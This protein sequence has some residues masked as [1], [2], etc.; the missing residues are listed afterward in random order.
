MAALTVSEY[1]RLQD[2][3][4]FPMQV[5]NEPAVVEQTPVAISAG[6][7]ESAAFAAGTKFVC[8]TTDTDCHWIVGT[9]P[10]ATT[11]HKFLPAGGYMVFGVRFGDK[12]S[13]IAA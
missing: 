7:A 12:V 10:V 1:A 4:A 8:I 3:A 13:V 5:L 9:A 11:S 6:H 2:G